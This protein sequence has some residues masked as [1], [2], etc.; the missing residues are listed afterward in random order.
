[1]N[2]WLSAMDRYRVSLDTF[3][4]GL[5]ATKRKEYIDGYY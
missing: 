5:L 3:A 1:M 2:D 4:D